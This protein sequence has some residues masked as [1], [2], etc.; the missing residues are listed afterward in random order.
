[1]SWWWKRRRWTVAIVGQESGLV[2]RL[3]FVRF[4]HEADAQLWVGHMNARYGDGLTC[5][6]VEKE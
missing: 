5:Y 6:R 4:R 3:T 2:T 1:M